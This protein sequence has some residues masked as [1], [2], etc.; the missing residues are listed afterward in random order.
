MTR[1]SKLIVAVVGAIATWASTLYPDS[2][3]VQQWVGLALALTTAFSVWAVPNQPPAG[4]PADPS[5]SEQGLTVL[6]IIVAVLVVLVLLAVL[7]L[8]R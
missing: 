3:A 8:I 1:Y 4:E 2:A 6:G 7:G 5:V